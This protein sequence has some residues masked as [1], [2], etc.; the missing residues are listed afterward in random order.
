METQS[1]T[2]FTDS[3]KTDES[4]KIKALGTKLLKSESLVPTFLRSAVSS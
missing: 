1:E 4:H 2:R 3:L